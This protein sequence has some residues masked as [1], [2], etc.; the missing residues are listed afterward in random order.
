MP[1]FVVRRRRHPGID[2]AVTRAPQGVN[3]HGEDRPVFQINRA[4]TEIIGV[5][6]RRLFQLSQHRRERVHASE[7]ESTIDR[8]KTIT[9]ALIHSHRVDAR[10]R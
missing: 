7:P 10:W 3:T 8:A 6:D 4:K 2:I 5:E 9:P 1:T